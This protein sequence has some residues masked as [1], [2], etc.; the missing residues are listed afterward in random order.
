MVIV[1][2]IEVGRDVAGMAG[3][4]VATCSWSVEPAEGRQVRGTSSGAR[5]AVRRDVPVEGSATGPSED[6]W[7]S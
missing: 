1:G 5:L 6:D 4:M 3:S 2:G 7:T